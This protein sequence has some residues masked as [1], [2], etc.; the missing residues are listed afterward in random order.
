M[1]KNY[2]VQNVRC[3]GCA[4]SIKQAL[5]ERLSLVEVDLTVMPRIV[6]AEIERDEDERFLRDTLR[7]R[8]YPL[9]GEDNGLF[10]Q[11]KSVISCAIGKTRSTDPSRP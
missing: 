6:S 4:R 5:S 3:E 10:D 7:R 2:A 1:I 11:A 8:G 9:V